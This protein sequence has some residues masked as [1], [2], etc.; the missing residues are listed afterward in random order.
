MFKADFFKI[1]S[2][3]AVNIVPE[4][5]SKLEIRIGYKIEMN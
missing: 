3:F 4:D 2:K 5:S 1:S